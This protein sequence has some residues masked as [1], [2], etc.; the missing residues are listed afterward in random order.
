M[1]LRPFAAFCFVVAISFAPI[2]ANLDQ[3]LSTEGVG[4]Y[5]D[6][7]FDHC[8]KRVRHW[9]ECNSDELLRLRSPVPPTVCCPRYGRKASL[10]SDGQSFDGGAPRFSARYSVVGGRR[11]LRPCLFPELVNSEEVV[12]RNRE[13]WG[14][15]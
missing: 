3:Q 7:K 8:G 9:H 12:L 13:R 5:R 6:S 14:P 1:E 10:A 15:R 11:T 2:L 4:R